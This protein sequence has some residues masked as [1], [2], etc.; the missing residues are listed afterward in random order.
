VQLD[1]SFKPGGKKPS[2]NEKLFNLHQFNDELK[3]A[4]GKNQEYP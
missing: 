3:K 4:A 1:T 2:L